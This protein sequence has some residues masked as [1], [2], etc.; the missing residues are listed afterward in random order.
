MLANGLQGGVM[1]D[2]LELAN[3]VIIGD[4]NLASSALN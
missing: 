2:A 1:R 4:S 3:Q